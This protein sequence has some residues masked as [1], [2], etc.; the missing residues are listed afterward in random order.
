MS[1][2]GPVEMND[3]RDILQL[4]RRLWSHISRRRRAHLAALGGLMLLGT[5]AEVLSLGMVLPFLGVLTAPDRIF[6]HPWARPLVD[7]LGLAG[8]EQL[9][10]PLTV[11]FGLAALFSGVTRVLLL[12]AQTRLGNDIGGELGSAAYRSTL[13][14][15]YS[16]HVLRNSGEVIA[17]LMTKV[18]TIIYFIIIP[19][20]TIVT[21][22]VIVATIAAFL[23]FIDPALTAMTFVGFGAFYAVVAYATRAQLQRDGRRVTLGQSRVAQAVQEGLGG[24]RDVLI[25]GLQETYSRIYRQTDR[26]LRRALANIAILGGAPRPIIES[27]G[28]VLIGGIAFAMSSRPEGMNGAIPILGT[29]ALAAQRLLPLVQ[30]GYAGWASM[31]GGQGSLRDVLDLLEQPLPGHSSLPPA[32][33]MPFKGQISLKDLHFRYTPDGHWVLRGIDLEIPRGSRTGF[34]GTT[35]SGKSTL[36]DIVMGLLTPTS[37]S[38]CIDGISVGMENH[39]AWQAHIAHVPQSIYLADTTIAENIAFGVAPSEIDWDRLRFAAERAQIAATIETWAEKYH[40]VVGERGVRLSGG[41]RQRIGIAR[42]LYKRADV[43]V[44]DEATS[45]LDAD[46]EQAVM[47]AIEAF[48]PDLTV[49]IVAHRVTTLRSCTQVV[50]LAQGRIARV[51]SYQALVGVSGMPDERE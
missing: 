15:P 16:V 48:D 51:G 34:I 27:V 8:P 17:V 32:A 7:G 23:L 29:L 18:N 4:L 13:Y 31:Q 47:E 43:L 1:Q 9:L 12:W 28:L 36:L 3:K 10:L 5:I 6:H 39:R 33:P 50:E 20:L 14:Q 37:G 46:T 40:T 42:A 30:Q 41:Q 21:S 45:A 2:V 49:L 19:F 26:Q 22:A 24:I 25:D 38:L 44:F 35:G 11:L